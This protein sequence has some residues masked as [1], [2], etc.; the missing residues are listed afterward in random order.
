[1]GDG[2]RGKVTRGSRLRATFHIF[3]LRTYARKIFV[4]V[5]ISTLNRPPKIQKTQTKPQGN[6]MCY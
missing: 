4:T 3:H 5:E 1:M 2:K 6:N